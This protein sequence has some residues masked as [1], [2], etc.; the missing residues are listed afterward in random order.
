MDSDLDTASGDCLSCSDP[1]EISMRMAHKKYRKR[2]RASCKL[3][4][5]M[6]WIDT[7][8]KRIEGGHQEVWGHDQKI[9][10][11]EWK[12]TLVDDCTSFEMRQIATRTD[13]LIHAAKATGSKIDTRESEAEAQGLA[14]GL[15][16][17]LKQFHVH[18]CRLYEKGTA[19]AIVGLQGLCLSDAFWN[20]N[21]L[22][23]MGLK[24]LCP[25]CLKFR[26][27][28]KTIATLLREV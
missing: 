25:W 12:C 21:M 23:S 11:A 26:G 1:D 24:S 27:N 16:L 18:Y 19:R 2:V 17:S 7:Q 13:Q 22:A 3:S 10:R 20:L 14:K 8:M 28:T 15:V 5:C 9:I 4:K 6:D